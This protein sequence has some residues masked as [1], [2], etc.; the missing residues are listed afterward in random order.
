MIGTAAQNGVKGIKAFIKPLS[1]LKERLGHLMQYRALRTIISGIAQG[2]GEGVKNM[3]LWSNALGGEFADAMDRLKSS[4]VLFKNSLAVA[5]APLIEWLAPRVEALANMFANL[6]T[7]VS[8]F[9]AILTGSDHYYTVAATSAKAYTSATGKATEKLRTLLKFDEIN[10]LERKNQSGGGSGKGGSTGGAF[11]RVALDKDVRN[12]SLPA[13]IKM[14]LD[15]LFFDDESVFKLFNGD[16]FVGS[17]CGAIG[18]GVLGHVLYK[19]AGMGGK[20]LISLLAVGLSLGFAQMAVDALGIKDIAENKIVGSLLSLPIGAGIGFI[21]G[22]PG[23]AIG[24]GLAAAAAFTFSAL[25]DPEISEATKG[26]IK[27]VLSGAF[28]SLLLVGGI[29]F[30]ATANPALALTV[31]IA[32]AALFT[33][34]EIGLKDP[35]EVQN[36]GDSLWDKVKGKLGIQSG[37]KTFEAEVAV[38]I[39]K[40]Y[41]TG[42]TSKTWQT[43]VNGSAGYGEI[44]IKMASGG[45]PDVGQLFVAREA[46]PE[47]VGTIGGRTAV[48]NNDQI[49]QGIASGVAN[50]NATQN[51]LLREQNSLLREIASKNMGITTGSLVDAF[52]RMNRREGS[53]VVPVGG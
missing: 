28:L 51:A 45:F 15:E 16:N 1:A 30:L 42:Q 19:H 47:M 52:G 10:R 20:L 36:K 31:G 37:K 43:V 26:K 49:V 18:V 53:T 21:L 8:R 27:S 14:I 32:A 46:G 22:G 12:L 2:F 23:L 13:R 24:V 40:I 50:A 48:A 3:Y 9:F 5:S 38:H 25:N 6:A 35:I 11:Q 41:A 33:F 34:K 29:T 17:L 44:Y 4:A 39:S 7:T